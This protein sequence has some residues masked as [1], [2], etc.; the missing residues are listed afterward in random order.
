V[1]RPLLPE[2]FHLLDRLDQHRAQLL[3][4]GLAQRVPQPPEVRHVG[5]DLPLQVVRL[6]VGRLQGRQL[7]GQPV[8]L[9]LKPHEVFLVAGQERRVDVP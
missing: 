6:V 9:P 3:R 1:G 8:A 5:L 7:P 4:A 2:E